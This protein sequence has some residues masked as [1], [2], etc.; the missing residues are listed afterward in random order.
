MWLEFGGGE[1][2]GGDGDAGDGARCGAFE[3]SGIGEGDGDVVFSASEQN[4]EV[5]FAFEGGIKL[6][7]G[8]LAFDLGGSDDARARCR[9]FDLISFDAESQNGSAG[10]PGS[11]VVGGDG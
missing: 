10:V 8:E 5:G 9:S 3:V 2:G 7:I 11:F 6:E 1:G 4:S